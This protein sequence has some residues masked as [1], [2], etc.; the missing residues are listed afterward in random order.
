MFLSIRFAHTAD[1]HIDRFLAALQSVNSAADAFPTQPTASSYRIGEGQACAIFVMGIKRIEWLNVWRDTRVYDANNEYTPLQT[2]MSTLRTVAGNRVQQPNTVAVTVPNSSNLDPEAYCKRC[3]HR[4]KNK[5]CYRLHPE[6]ASK[7]DN[8]FG[9][10]K[11]KGKQ[12]VISYDH[13]SD[14]ESDSEEVDIAASSRMNET[15]TL[16]DTGASHHFLPHKSYFREISQSMNSF[17]I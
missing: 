14:S 11:G 17:K 12:A 5:Y 15:D 9:A 3:H 8:R 6:L 13:S 7:R 16:Y 4:H 2:L 1:D 10:Y